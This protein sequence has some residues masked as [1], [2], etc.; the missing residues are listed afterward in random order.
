[1][2]GTRLAADTVNVADTARLGEVDDL[3]RVRAGNIKARRADVDSRP[4]AVW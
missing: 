2:L 1:M 3:L 4:D